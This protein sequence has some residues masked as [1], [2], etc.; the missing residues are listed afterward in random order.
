MEALIKLLDLVEITYGDNQ[1]E[2]EEAMAEGTIRFLKF[3]HGPYLRI[4]NL[5][6]GKP[7]KFLA[8][9]EEVSADVSGN[10]NKVFRQAVLGLQT[11]RSNL[12]LL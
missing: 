12:R 4:T 11:V 3:I 5:L 8:N 10:I 9:V 2:F 7:P 6:N 1:N